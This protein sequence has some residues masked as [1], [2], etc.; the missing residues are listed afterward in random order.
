MCYNKT[1]IAAGEGMPMRRPLLYA[2]LAAALTLLAAVCL[3]FPVML[4]W[5]LLAAAGMATCLVLR[6]RETA[7]VFLPACLAAVAAGVYFLV[8]TAAQ[9]RPVQEFGEREA[10][11]SGVIQEEPVT[12]DGRTVYILKVDACDLEGFPPDAK[13]RITDSTAQRAEA[14]D[15]YTARV[16]LYV[17][18]GWSAA[19]Y[20][21][22]G[23]YLCGAAAGEQAVERAESRPPYYLAIRARQYVRSFFETHLSY[24]EAAALNGLLLGDKAGMTV[25]QDAAF[26]DSGISHIMAVSGM[27]LAVICQALLA[28][29]RKLRVGRRPSALIA[30]AAVLI[31]MAVTGFSASI[32]RAG[33]TYLIMLA[34]SLFFARADGLNS[35][36]GAVLAILV[37]NPYNIMDLSLQLSV[38]ATLGILAACPPLCRRLEK[39]LPAGLPGRILRPAAFI[40]AQSAVCTLFTLPVILLR[41]DQ[42]SLV[43]PLTNLAVSFASTAALLCGLLALL[44]SLWPPLMAFGYPLLLAAGLLI[45]YI[46]WA[47]AFF[48]GLPFATAPTGYGYLQVFLA[49]AFLLIGLALL[50]P[51]RR[52]IYRLTVILTAVL[53]LAGSGS[54][55]AFSGGITRV[56]LL[57]TGSGL[58]ALLSRGGRNAL[59]GAGG[60][61]DAYYAVRDA[62]PGYGAG[63]LDLVAL[64]SLDTA[65]AGGL[66]RL[67]RDAAADMLA[68]PGG[69]D[70]A[71][72]LSLAEGQIRAADWVEGGRIEL[73]GDVTIHSLSCGGQTGAYLQVG[74]TSFL[75]L[76]TPAFLSELPA[77][78]EEY[79]ALLTT[80]GKMAGVSASPAA[81]G[82]VGGDADKAERGA[83]YLTADGLPSYAAGGAGSLTV[84]TRGR[85]DITVRRE[86]E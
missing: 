58:A 72:S 38:C 65:Y 1:E 22:D 44:L 68:L 82:L 49:G 80:A 5:I 30:M 81:A 86:G 70:Y 28:L 63:C 77:E 43:A 6:K 46:G 53:F 31:I 18:E 12:E 61:A 2:A 14:F 9:V 8:I 3:P 71:A 13:L 60:E 37:L 42:V 21:A 26:R 27:H 39:K 64:P 25:Q 78:Y 34:G 35:L 62:V 48:A 17:P 11:V 75:L 55:A 23:I 19:G 50:L 36:G 29:L 16:W 47:A 41:L 7:R 10:L 59:I 73:W 84:L 57:D 52:R 24:H 54:Y 79:Q 51:G 20:Y 56:T 85:G 66:P 45:R 67:L 32:L 74:G 33:I 83:A 4:A 15:R 40:L 76:P 69:Q